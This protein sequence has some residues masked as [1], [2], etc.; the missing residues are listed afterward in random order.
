YVTTSTPKLTVTAKSGATVQFKM[1]GTVVATGTETGTGT[2]VYTASIPAGKLGVGANSITAVVSDSTG[3]STDSTALSL[4]YAPTYAGGVY[5]VPGAAGSAQQVAIAWT[6]RRAA[7][8]DEIGY[9]IVNSADGS[10]NGVAPGS[11][12]YAKAALTSST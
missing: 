11:A 4:I 3:T 7:Y 12:G 5:T 1:G 10:V 8:N 2:G 6:V 9:F